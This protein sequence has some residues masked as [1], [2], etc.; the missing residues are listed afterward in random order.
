V[1][2][3]GSTS[4]L[5]LPADIDPDRSELV[6]GI[7]TSPLAVINGMYRQLA[8]YPFDCTEQIA[9]ELMPIV[10]LARAGNA[11][12]AQRLSPADARAR[13]EEAV[14]VLSR[15]Q[16]ADGGIGLW[17][18]DDWTTPWLSAWAGEALLGARSAG[19]AVR[20]S[21]LGRLGDFLYRNIHQNT[22]LHGPVSGW[23]DD[24][25]VKL[26]EDVA[27]LDFLRQLGRPD[28]PGENDALR[29]ASILAWEDRARLAEVMAARGDLA[30][31]R[32]LI[33]PL[34]AGV[35]IEGRR[36]TLPDS[37]VRRFYFWSPRRP[38]ARLL[39]ATLAVDS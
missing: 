34:W 5:T 22:G 9:S 37:A 2:R 19:V 20:D 11:A 30:A 17:S 6:F 27:S 39:S 33:E 18:A 7:G 14:A 8:I 26:G 38:L 29:R 23:L 1:T 36:A 13:I 21:V 3:D 16:R 28:V 4:E 32:R 24:Q 12:G 35:R 25:Q 10:A 15:R 31:A